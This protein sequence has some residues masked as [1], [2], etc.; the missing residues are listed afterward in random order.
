MTY[1]LGSLT[2]ATTI[3]VVHLLHIE[4]IRNLLCRHL[5]QLL[6]IVKPAIHYNI[7]VNISASHHHVWRWLFSFLIA[8]VLLK[9]VV[10]GSHFLISSSLVQDPLS[11]FNFP[12]NETLDW[13]WTKEKL[14]FF[15]GLSLHVKIS[16]AGHGFHAEINHSA[17][18]LNSFVITWD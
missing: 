17:A 15:L 4:F 9:T 5:I 1:I 3:S 7:F 18:D 2:L 14:S 10:K 8:T 13:S 11:F 16:S 6:L 12:F